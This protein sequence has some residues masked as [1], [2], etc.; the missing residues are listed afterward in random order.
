M[1]SIG[2][3]KL[4]FYDLN[5][6]MV[7]YSS[8]KDSPE[9]EKYQE[10]AAQLKAFDPKEL[11]SVEQKKA[12]WINLYN[13][14]VVHGIVELGITFS[15]R[16][17]SDF[18]SNITYRIGEYTFSADEMEHGVLRA[19]ARRPYGLFPI[20]KQNDP[21]VRFSLDKIDSRIHFALVCGSRSCAPIRF[22]EADVI[23]EQLDAAARNFIN[24]SEVLI[25]PEKNKV[26]LSQIFNW[27]KRDF[28]GREKIF[29][30]L[31]QYLDKDEK[32]KFLKKNMTRID[33]GYLF[34]DWNLNH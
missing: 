2:D 14:I 10:I 33:V 13:T 17:I 24:S 27:Y 21:R 30:F 8:M 29:R 34:Y 31:L 18:F 11:S 15:I 9:Y 6:G 28:G 22:Y 4:R 20:L 5:R 26:F 12:F 19:N 25:L 1:A 3:L 7:D 16:E 32:S 23:D